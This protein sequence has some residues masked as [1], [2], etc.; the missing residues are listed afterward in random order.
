MKKLMMNA[1]EL[2][3]LDK[4]TEDEKLEIIQDRHLMLIA[5]K[6]V[7]YRSENKI[8]QKILAE[9]LNISQVMISKIENGKYNISNKL[10]FEYCLQ[11]GIP[12][13]K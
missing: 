6:F 12:I 10:L 4:V 7:K 1:W 3:E 13:E 5:A 9:K 2:L 8:T 11:L